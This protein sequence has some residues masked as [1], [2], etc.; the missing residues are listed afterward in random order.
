L[1]MSFLET[2]VRP[3]FTFFAAARL[4]IHPSFNEGSTPAQAESI[5]DALVLTS[6]SCAYHSGRPPEKSNP[7]P[8]AYQMNV[9]IWIGL[10][11]ALFAAFVWA[12]NV[13]VPFVIGRYSVFDFALIRFVA[14]GMGTLV[15]G[16]VIAVRVFE[17]QR[18]T[19][20]V[21]N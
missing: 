2:I 10:L 3:S 7:A 21:P 18:Q 11:S 6:Q 17:R 1:V 8:R 12:L 14:A 16:V 4:I 5:R 15:L 13:I 19:A 20:L 9:S